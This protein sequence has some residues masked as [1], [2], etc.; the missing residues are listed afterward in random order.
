MPEPS[1]MGVYVLRSH[2]PV[3]DD[4]DWSICTFQ[5][6]ASVGAGGLTVTVSARVLERLASGDLSRPLSAAEVMQLDGH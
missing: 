5:D 3:A 4:P 6:P 2:S 1:T